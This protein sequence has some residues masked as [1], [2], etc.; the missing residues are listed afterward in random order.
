MWHLHAVTRAFKHTNSKELSWP[1]ASMFLNLGKLKCAI[2]NSTFH[3]WGIKWPHSQ[4]HIP[5]MR[6]NNDLILSLTFHQWGIITTSFPA[7]FHPWGIIMTSFSGFKLTCSTR[8][9]GWRSFFFRPK[10]QTFSLYTSPE[11]CLKSVG[12]LGWDL[13]RWPILQY[14]L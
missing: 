12:I 4:P 2:V 7:S 10:I 1:P 8:L 9:I 14:I 11:L 3:Q 13:A 6:D 5:S